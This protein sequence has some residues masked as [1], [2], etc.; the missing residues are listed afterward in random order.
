[1]SCV[2]CGGKTSGWDFCD[3]CEREIREGQELEAA[4]EEE[5]QR[6]RAIAAAAAEAARLTADPVPGGPAAQGQT[7]GEKPEQKE[8]EHG[9]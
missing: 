4:I 8:D 1:M 6:Q 3:G 9:R 7:T 5:A 2:Q